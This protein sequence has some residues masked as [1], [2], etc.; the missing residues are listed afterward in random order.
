MVFPP[1]V[2]LGIPDRQFLY[3]LQ[4]RNVTLPPKGLAAHLQPKLSES[5]IRLSSVLDME[6]QILRYHRQEERQMAHLL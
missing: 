3:R 5:Y 2:W 4:S 6:L 1:I